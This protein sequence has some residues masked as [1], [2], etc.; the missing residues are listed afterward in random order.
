MENLIT[1]NNHKILKPIFYVTKFIFNYSAPYNRNSWK[2][3]HRLKQK[4]AKST[5]SNLPFSF[6][7]Q[8]KIIWHRQN[9][10]RFHI[11][12]CLCQ[13]FTYSFVLRDKSSINFSISI[14]I[15]TSFGSNKNTCSFSKHFL[16]SYVTGTKFF[17][18]KGKN[19]VVYN[20]YMYFLTISFNL[21]I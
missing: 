16:S 10:A 8:M 2:E 11:A 13:P 7:V 9:A 6:A 18:N 4:S 14:F 3:P 19:N 17:I 1:R 12:F 20:I 15:S 21:F 5:I